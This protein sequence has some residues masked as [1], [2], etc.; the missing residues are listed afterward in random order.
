MSVFKTKGIV[1]LESNMGDNDKMLTILTPNGKIG[2][3][4]KGAKRPK[5]NLMAGTQYLCFGEFSLYK[6]ASSYT[7]NIA[8]PI[9]IFYNVRL[10]ID[11]LT[12]ASK[13]TKL[14]N[15]V[16]DE[17]QNTYRVLQ[18]TLNTIYM[19]SESDKELDFIYS[20]FK[21][22]L[23]SII[24]FKPVIEGC[25]TCNEKKVS[26]FSLKDN[27]FKCEACGKQ[28]KGAIKLSDTTI[29]AIR[30]IIRSDAKK[31]YSFDLSNENKTQLKM[32]AKLY[33]NKCL[34]K[35]YE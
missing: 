29:K 8:E 11:K 16:T 28:D 23:L 24:G 14:V 13:V 5:S 35:E 30:Y 4:A 2:C 19:F 20:I 33:L 15:E 25:S 1:L 17:N 26:Y 32:V 27:G 31:I 18:L 10:D 12:Y 6:S 22:R 9:E 3:S 34:D 21:M 7:I